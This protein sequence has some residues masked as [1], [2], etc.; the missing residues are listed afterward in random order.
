[1]LLLKFF[2]LLV[3]EHTQ[4]QLIAGVWESFFLFGKWHYA[5]HLLAD[6]FTLQVYYE[7]AETE[8]VVFVS[9]QKPKFPVLI[10]KICIPLTT[11][12]LGAMHSSY[13]A[14]LAIK[15]EQN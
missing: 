7:L 3:V 9:R 10:L 2:P 15:I 1:M 12:M 13:L 11:W 6:S 5:S 14:Y 8:L 4:K